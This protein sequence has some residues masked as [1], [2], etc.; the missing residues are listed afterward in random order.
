MIVPLQCPP[1]SDDVQAEWKMHGTLPKLYASLLEMS[2][3]TAWA[4]YP[5]AG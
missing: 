3:A 5:A 2:N 4:R 1:G